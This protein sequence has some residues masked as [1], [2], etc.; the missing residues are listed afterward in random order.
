MAKAKKRSKPE[1][2]RCEKCDR[3]FEEQYP[4]NV[5]VHQGRVICKDCLVEMGVMPDTAQPYSV[6][7]K[8]VTDMGRSG[9]GGV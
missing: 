7:T 6:M 9:R 5:Y 4:E 2:V 8:M 1:H 3:E